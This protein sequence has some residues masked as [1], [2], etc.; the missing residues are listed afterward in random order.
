MKHNLDPEDL[1]PFRL[2]NAGV[3]VRVPFPIHTV[4]LLVLS[5]I[6][7]LGTGSTVPFCACTN[8]KLVILAVLLQFGDREREHMSDRP[9]DGT[10]FDINCV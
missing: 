4:S 10:I 9:N 5:F 7:S 3:P 6:S 2:Q 1:Q 8:A